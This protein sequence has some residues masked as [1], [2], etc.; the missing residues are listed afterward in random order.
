MSHRKCKKGD[1]L[2]DTGKRGL[3]GEQL[4]K[5]FSTKTMDFASSPL[6]DDSYITISPT[7]SGSG[8]WKSCT[9]YSLDS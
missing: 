6:C 5:C 1:I 9:D 2:V 7:I 4:Y 3:D 8:R